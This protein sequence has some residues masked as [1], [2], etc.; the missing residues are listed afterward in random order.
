VSGLEVVAPNSYCCTLYS[1][2]YHLNYEEHNYG[3]LI[4]VDALSSNLLRMLNSQHTF[5]V[6]S[7]DIH[8]FGPNTSILRTTM[9]TDITVRWHNASSGLLPTMNMSR[10]IAEAIGYTIPR[11]ETRGWTVDGNIS[12][13]LWGPNIEDDGL[14]HSLIS[15]PGPIVDVQVFHSTWDGHS[16]I[17]PSVGIVDGLRSGIVTASTNPTEVGQ[18]VAASL[19]EQ[20]R[21]AARAAEGGITSALQSAS[22]ATG[23]SF[24]DIKTG[25][26]LLSAGVGIILVIKLI[27][28]VKSV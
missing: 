1:I 25:I 28:E 18:P 14:M 16:Q 27:K 11:D 4:D 7:I 13:D 24:T 10:M 9:E 21:N 20:A 3:H 23:V 19:T 26:S 12:S 2:T 8:T 6:D 17:G 5:T 22:N 15:F